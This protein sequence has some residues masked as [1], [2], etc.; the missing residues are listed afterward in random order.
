MP[1]GCCQ[2]K[3]KNVSGSGRVI[4]LVFRLISL[5]FS[6]SLVFLVIFFWFFWLADFC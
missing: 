1:C 4:F 5:I 6:L 3:E 2:R